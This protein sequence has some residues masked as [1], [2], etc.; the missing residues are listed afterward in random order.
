L[1]LLENEAKK[2]SGDKRE[3]LLSFMSDP[4]HSDDAAKY[5]HEALVIFEKY[6][7]R[8]QV[9]TKNPELALRDIDL[10]VRNNWKIATTALFTSENMRREFE[11]G[12]PSMESRF[13]SILQFHSA[14]VYTWVSI[15]PIID[16]KE[17]LGV[18][19]RMSFVDLI[20]IGR[21][22]YDARANKIDWS[23]V[24]AETSSLCRKLGVSYYIKNDLF[25]YADEET[26]S[27]G[28]RWEA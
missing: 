7:L 26:K 10:F 8:C 6:G 2:L 3:I 27:F 13:E 22:N 16:L 17:A 1:R 24:A 15:E 18:I 14:G 23:V 5:T 21:W 9:L 19:N 4:Y 28:Q 20:K 11:Q 25:V 12:A